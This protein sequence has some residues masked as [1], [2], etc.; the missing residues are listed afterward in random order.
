M[1]TIFHSQ[2]SFLCGKHL[3]PSYDCSLLGSF[4]RKIAFAMFYICKMD[5]AHDGVESS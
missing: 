1:I 4:P 5:I 3:F 2:S